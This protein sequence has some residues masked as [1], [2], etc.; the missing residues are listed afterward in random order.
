MSIKNFDQAIKIMKKHKDKTHL[1]VPQSIKNIEQAEKILNLSFPKSYK[2]FLA[3]CGSLSIGSQDIFGLTNNND[4][5]QYIYE[6]VVCN[7]LDE[8]LNQKDPPFQ[9]YLI[10]V[11]ALG[12][13]EISC[14]DVLYL[15]A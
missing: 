3:M 7:T 5:S 15:W 2:K 14:L 1:F 8:R 13:G 4:F 11:H 6:N 9:K 12:N 10:P